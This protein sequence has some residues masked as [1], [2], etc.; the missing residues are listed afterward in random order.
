MTHKN[1]YEYVKNGVIKTKNSIWNEPVNMQPNTFVSK[2]KKLF[3]SESI[4]PCLFRVILTYK[5]S[6]FL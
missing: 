4:L 3:Y 5:K 1:N 6:L 2:D